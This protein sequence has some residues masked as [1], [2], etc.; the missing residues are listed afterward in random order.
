MPAYATPADLIQRKD[1]RTVGNLASD[2]GT[3][4]ALPALLEDP[5]VLA[6]LADASGKIESA[7]LVGERY[8]IVDLQSLEDNSLAY[9]KRITCDIA[10]ALMYE[11]RPYSDSKD[12]AKAFDAAN[13]ALEALRQGRNVFT[14]TS[15]IGAT[16]P[17]VA[18]PTLVQY[19]NLRTI[20]ARTC[21]RFYPR[22]V[23]PTNE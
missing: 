14:L 4:V 12:R 13:D 2:T 1:A 5:N 3:T 15:Q 6:A 20:V 9:L 18:T 17:E 19:N 11:R 22:K 23:F 10:F 7:L 21:N 8:S 16:V